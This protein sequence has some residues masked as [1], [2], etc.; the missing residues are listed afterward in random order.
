MEEL[1]NRLQELRVFKMNA[2]SE[3]YQKTEM[4]TA[5]KN[6]IAA[7]EEILKR[8]ENKKPD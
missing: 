7:L 8:A 1:I 5:V 3:I 6:Q 2:E 4:L